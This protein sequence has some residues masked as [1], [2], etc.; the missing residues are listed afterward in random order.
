MPRILVNILANIYFK[1]MRV[2]VK[3]MQA[4]ILVFF[5][6][7]TMLAAKEMKANIK[8]PFDMVVKTSRR[9]DGGERN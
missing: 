5:F 8:N 7:K 2:W 9:D 3:L 1:H 6:S 4:H